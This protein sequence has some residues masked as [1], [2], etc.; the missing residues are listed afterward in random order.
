M[1]KS[2]ICLLL[3]QWLLSAAIAR[4]SFFSTSPLNDGNFDVNGVKRGMSK[5]EPVY[6]FLEAENSLKFSFPG[7]GHDFPTAVRLQAYEFIE[8]TFRD[9]K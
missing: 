5:V 4:Q 1:N 9:I 6:R 8:Q 3:L 7:C 2:I